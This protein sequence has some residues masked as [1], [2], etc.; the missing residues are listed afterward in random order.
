MHIKGLILEAVHAAVSTVESIVDVTMSSAFGPQATQGA[1]CDVKIVQEKAEKT[2]ATGPDD[3]VIMRSLVI[4]CV[5]EAPVPLDMSAIEL[6]HNVL[7]AIEI[8]V[9]NDPAL[10][11]LCDDCFISGTDYDYGQDN[12]ATGIGA[13]VFFTITYQTL[14]GNPGERF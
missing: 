11:A 10:K 7:A 5:V 12:Q 13:A 6:E 3:G 8:T 14:A 1:V 2:E 9:V 4:A